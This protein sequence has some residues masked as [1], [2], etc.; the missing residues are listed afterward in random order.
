MCGMPR[1][2]R[3]EH[4]PSHAAADRRGRPCA[5]EAAEVVA[6]SLR[7]RHGGR[8]GQRRAAVP[9][10]QPRRRHDGSGPAAGPR[11]RLRGLQVPGEAAG[12]R[13]WREGH[14]ADG[15]ERPG[16]RTARHPHGRV[17]LPCQACRPRRAGPHR[18]TRFPPL[19]TAAGEPPPADAAEQRRLLR[20]GHARPRHATR[21]PHDR[22]GRA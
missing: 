10:Q 9:P 18:R 11:L 17:R 21:L 6:G 5:A 4:A 1:W 20:P 2:S 15:A 19:R 16:Q 12:T 8:R 3:D 22:E 13:P 7:V 14:R